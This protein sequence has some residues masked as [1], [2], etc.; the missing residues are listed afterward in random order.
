MESQP[1][2]NQSVSSVGNNN[3]RRG[4]IGFQNSILFDS[5]LAS[6]PNG[7]QLKTLLDL[8]EGGAEGEEARILTER[9][10]KL[11][12]KLERIVEIFLN[13]VSLNQQSNMR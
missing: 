4:S 1:L 9:L 11:R 10:G 3:G 6:L 7:S 12:E 8:Q 5:S 2:L 13:E